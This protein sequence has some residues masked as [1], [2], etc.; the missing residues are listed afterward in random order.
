MNALLLIDIQ[1]DFLPGG[2][3][4]APHGDE[5]IPLVNEMIHYPFDLIVATKDWHPASHESFA[6]NHGMQPGEHVNLGGVDQILWPA[7]CIEGTLGAE[8]APGWDSIDI[9]KVIYKG[10]DPYI[11]SYS[12]F[13]DNGHEK[14]TGLDAYLKDKGVRDIFIAGLVTDYCVKYTVLDALQLG[15]HPFV[16]IDACRGVNLKPDDSQ[17]AFIVMLKAGAVLLHFKDLKDLL[18]EEN[19]RKL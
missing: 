1:N 7:H 16:I 15:F 11:D 8:F 5:I 18:D 19:L 6:N 9:D 14:S 13:F 17:Q 10:T 4:P 3:L 2:A 12:A